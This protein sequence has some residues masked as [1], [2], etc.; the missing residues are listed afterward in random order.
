M[1]ET[2]HY[3]NGQR[4]YLSCVKDGATKE[5][6]AHY[7][8]SFLGLSLVQR[9][10]KRLLNRLDGEVHPEALKNRDPF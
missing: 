3:G 5:I 6:L 8:S 9:T 10:V 4:A 2:M 1:N 7:L